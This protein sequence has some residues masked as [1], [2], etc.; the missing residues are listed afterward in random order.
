MLR[1]VTGE[2]ALLLKN[3]ILVIADL[4]IGIEKEYREAGLFLPDQTS[5]L[6]K[7]LEKL[8]RKTK[9]K[10]IIVLG[11]LK[12]RIPGLGP[13]EERD[14]PE[15]CKKFKI[16]LI[17][18]NHDGGLKDLQIKIHSV[19]GLLIGDVFLCHGHAWPGEDVNKAK[20]LVIAHTHPQIEFTDSLGHRWLE[21]VWIRARTRKCRKLKSIDLIVMPAFNQFAGG[22]A[23]NRSWL[24]G[25]VSK[26]VKE[27]RAYLLDGTDLGSFRKT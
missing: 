24:L 26:L 22:T 19:K 8:V 15:F 9:A 14:I 10:K 13:K 11:D 20:T 1:F 6:A 18:G 23:V 2:P 16:E 21:P 12:H 27:V 7:K 4:H 5:F 25:P 3:R 17:P